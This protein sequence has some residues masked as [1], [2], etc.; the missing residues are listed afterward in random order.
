MGLLDFERNGKVDER[1]IANLNLVLKIEGS[2]SRHVG[3]GVVFGEITHC[4]AW[5]KGGH[6]VKYGL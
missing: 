5:M 1:E 3:V 2:G 4:N 6:F